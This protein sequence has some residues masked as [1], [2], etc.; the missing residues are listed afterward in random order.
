MKRFKIAV[1]YLFALSLF[2]SGA[3]AKDYTV[4]LISYLGH[5]PFIIADEKGFFA[6]ENINLKAKYYHTVDEWFKAFI[7]DRVD[8]SIFWNSS[9]IELLLSGK[10]SV[11]LGVISYEKQDHRLIAKR[12]IT[13]Q[14]LKTQKIGYPRELFG[15]RWFLW[16]YLKPHNI[17]VSE[18]HPITMSEEDLLK[19]FV[20][21]RLKIVML[22]GDYADSAVKDGNGVILTTSI[23]E[24]TLNSVVMSEENYKATPKDDLKKM[25]RALIHATEWLSDPANKAEYFSIIKGKFVSNPN[26]S[27]VQDME[28][29][30]QKAMGRMSLIEKKD[31]YEYN[32]TFLKTSYDTMKNIGTEIAMPYH[33]AYSEIVDTA[34]MLE[35]LEEMGLGM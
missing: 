11:S 27:N 33:F 1:I 25:H 14:D 9:H 28:S 4:A 21:G 24:A 30:V 23:P 29:F 6:K 18:T 34:A 31:L 5:S 19:N 2:V 8:I 13:P 15:Y 7:H 20:V 16:N 32:S 3:E 12:E 35:V 26:F 22:L 17:K 10:K